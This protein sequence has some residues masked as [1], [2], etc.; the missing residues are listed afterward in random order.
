MFKFIILLKFCLC[1]FNNL[2]KLFN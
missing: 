1:Y 2:I